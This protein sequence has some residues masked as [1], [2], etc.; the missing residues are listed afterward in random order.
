MKLGARQCTIAML[1]AGVTVGR[2][3]AQ[4][5]ISLQILPPELQLDDGSDTPRVVVLG[6]T[7]SG[8]T[9]DVTARV[10]WEIDG[11]AFAEMRSVSGIPRLFGQSDGDTVLVARFGAVAARA[12]VRVRGSAV[13]PPVSFRNEV[14]PILTRSGCNTGSCHGAAVGKN[15]FLLSL[16]AYDPERDH[17]MLTRDL[18]GRR[19]DLAQPEQSLI[20][21]KPGALVPHQGGK[22]LPSDGE[23]H[24]R[25]RAWIAGGALDD[26]KQAATL[27]GIDLLPASAVAL[28]GAVLPLQVRAR[29]SDGSDRDVTALT[30]WSSSNDGAAV[31]VGDG[32]V[33]MVANGE[34]AVLARFSGF[35]AS[36]QVL[37]LAADAP[38]H[39]P[40]V[41]E[42]GFVDRAA[43]DKLR[44]ARVLPAAVCSDEVFV[45]RVHLDLVGL[46]PSPEAARSFLADPTT[47]KRAR[48]VDALLEDPAFAT[49]QAMHWAE[50][51]RVD[52]ERME[53]KG[54]AL[55]TQWLQRSFA[56]HRPFDA[57]VRE[58]LT[59]QGSNYAEPVAS[60][61]LVAEQPN[62]LAEHV[63]QDFLGVRMQCAQCHDHPFENWTMNDYYG[64][65]A[66]F[67]QLARKRGEDGVEWIVWDRRSGD[68][69]NRRDNA[70]SKP[71]YL[72]G[73]EAAIPKD[74]DRRAALAAWLTAPDNPWFARNVVNRLWAQLFGRGI[75]EPADDVRVS[76][77]PSHPELLQQLAELFTA[78]HFDV[79]P[80]VR[81]ICTSRT[82]QLAR[83]PD[84]APAA[85]FAGNQVRRL[86]AEQLL[87][88]IGAVT[89][90]PT[91]YPGVPPGG[92]AA[93]IA[94]GR[95]DVRFL[96]VFGRPGRESACTCERRPE[97]TLGQT[98][99]LI[100]GDT[101]AGKIADQAGRLRRALAAGSTSEAMLDDLFLAAYARTP[102]AAERDGLLVPVRAASDD[103]TLL[104]AWQDLYWAVLNSK[105]FLF[106]H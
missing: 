79:R 41:A 56:E 66:F 89:A 39:W 68:V 85:L 84:A 48:L 80:V 77:P 64:F 20:L 15:G 18:R 53:P 3:A 30:L 78:E 36:A 69:R 95:T 29:Y 67:G 51:L 1:A 14:L 27:L 19:I 97:P 55:L 4:E 62:L 73:A 87:D 11:G 43:H 24:E 102:T 42:T 31:C 74:Q 54:A 106:Q 5:P 7:S 94:S 75:V 37:V 59:A 34:T 46:L 22:K 44:R 52:A 104:A 99:H 101:I 71:R 38:F 72:G 93:A 2:P 83:H 100:N 40:D 76:N 57:M 28:V 35:A 6:A 90:V 82:Y 70:V 8:I 47:D 12:A 50:V 91:K 65:A 9:I 16:F 21:Q 60:F 86:S 49:V 32:A 105:E 23:L 103:E 13:Q 17:R 88:A 58:L 26:C 45:R 63:A 10:Q 92:S 25:V 98:L 33:R 61:W 81:A 96:E